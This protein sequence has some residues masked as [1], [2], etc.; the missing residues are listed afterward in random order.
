[1]NQ[2]KIIEQLVLTCIDTAKAMLDEYG[3]VVPFGIR[4]FNDSDDLKMNCPADQQQDAD[5]HEQINNVATEL[6]EFIANENIF[7]T[8]LV[9]ELESGGES[10]IGL[11][12]ET[13]MS[14]VLFVYPFSK[15][16]GD[17]KIDEPIQTDQVLASIFSAQ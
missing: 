17:W 3:L 14:S 8:A 13:E 7:A 9:T 12:I 10:G 6:K 4:A 5:W 15:Q 1:M 11:Q 16:D 2:D